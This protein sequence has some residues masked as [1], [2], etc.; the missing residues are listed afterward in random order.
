MRTEQMILKQP[1]DLYKAKK[2]LIDIAATYPEKMK[3]REKN[4]LQKLID[5]L[6]DMIPG[7][8]D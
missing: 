7:N 5:S 4:G 3:V 2:A 6:D 1:A 8:I